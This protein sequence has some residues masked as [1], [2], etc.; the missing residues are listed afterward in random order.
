MFRKLGSLCTILVV[1]LAG[2]GSSYTGGSNNGGSGG[3]SY[4]GQAQG[5]YSGTSSNGYTFESIV[6]PND[7]FYALYGMVTGT[8]FFVDGIMTGQGASGNGTYTA[9][10][11]DFFN[12]G[13]IHS[14]SLTATDVPGSS[15]NGS[16][17]ENGTAITFTGTALASSSFNYGT[18]AS[19]SAISGIWNGNLLDGMSTTVTINPN[20]TVSG[21]SA[22]C[23]FT[24]MVT[25]DSSNKNFFDVSLTFGASPC[26]F[27]N[28]T[29][30]GI[31]V[32][33]LLSDG[34]THQLLAAVSLGTSIGT[35][36]FAQR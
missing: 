3:T 36:F 32:Y 24:G 30:T 17:T 25:A 9:S 31:A 18:A 26:A 27:P 2:C 28:Q 19:V 8:S 21:S 12:T 16:I 23:S 35:V 33:Y 29:A 5:V 4:A 14:G 22:G 1:L 10:I 7:K 34:V 6:L 13:T 20:G 11:S 15:I